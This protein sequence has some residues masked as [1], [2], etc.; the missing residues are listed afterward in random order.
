MNHDNCE[1]NI[2]ELAAVTGGDKAQPPPVKV[3]GCRCG[4]GGGGQNG[5]GPGT[6]GGNGQGGWAGGD[7]AGAV[8][9]VA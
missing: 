6:G 4:G 8:A 5:T 7:S 1:L 2:D 3:P 9:N